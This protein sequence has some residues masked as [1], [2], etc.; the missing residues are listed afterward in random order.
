LIVSWLEIRDRPVGRTFRSQSANPYF[1]TWESSQ[2]C[3]RTAV[4][5]EEFVPCLK[6]NIGKLKI[7]CFRVICCGGKDLGC[8]LS[9]CL[10]SWPIFLDR[11]NAAF[12]LGSAASGFT[13]WPN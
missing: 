6:L 5:D 11:H 13:D 9:I 3:C 10:D 2:L 1:C 7:Q 12:E 8:Q 4:S